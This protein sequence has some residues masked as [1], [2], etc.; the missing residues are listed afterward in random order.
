MDGEWIRFEIPAPV[1]GL[2]W[3]TTG[4]AMPCMAAQRVQNRVMA[5]RPQFKKI[6]FLAPRTGMAPHEFSTYWREVHGPTVANAPGYAAYRTCYAQNHWV[7]DGPV[8]G[9][10]P[11][12]GI[13]VFHLPGDGSNEQAFAASPTYRDHIRIDELNFIDMD[14]TLSMT[15]IE[16]VIRPSR[17]AVPGS[18]AVKVVI[19]GACRAGLD[20]ATFDRRLHD[21]C[22]DALVTARPFADHLQGWTLNHIIAGSFQLPGARAAE[23][24]TLACMQE[25]WFASAQARDQAF[26]SSAYRDHLGPALQD[27]F[28][29]SPLYSFQ[30]REIVFF[31]LGRPVGDPIGD[32]GG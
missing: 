22:T 28:A 3:P 10:F 27:L 21:I 23:A 24:S 29:D 17:G 14:R 9:H 16:N 26:G 8:G 30:A 1:P 32:P 4:G 11:H 31:D 13:A 19:L 25:L 2:K 15:A 7:G 5:D 12:P 20:R 6:A 18:G